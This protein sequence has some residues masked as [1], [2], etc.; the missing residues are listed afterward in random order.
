MR[1]LLLFS[2]FII[3]FSTCIDPF[4]PG[5]DS[6]GRK[7]VVDG[8]L[9]NLPDAYTV[10]L[11]YSEPY[12]NDS[13]TLP[14]TQATV[15][16]AD[17][18]GN[19]FDLQHVTQG[20]Y[21][22][23]KTV[24]QG[25]LGRTYTLHIQTPDGK[26]YQSQPEKMLAP[27]PIDTVFTRFV[28]TTD[29][30]EVS[31]YYFDAYVRTQDPKETENFYQWRWT[32]FRQLEFCQE[33]WDSQARIFRQF[34]CC[35]PCWAIQRCVGSNCIRIESD[36]Y[37]NGNRFESY[38]AQVPFD[39]KEAYFIAIDQLALSEQTY[40]F[41]Q[42]VNQQLNNTGGI[43]DVPPAAAVGNIFNP[44]DP[45]EQVLGIFNVAGATRK[46]VYLRRD[47]VNKTPITKKT[48]EPKV[49]Q[50]NCTQCNESLFRTNNKPEGW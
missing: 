27:P 41:W 17:D 44:A 48:P 13:L 34:Y 40:R 20:N 36:L 12:N 32:H 4:D 9:T 46:A 29:S 3:S 21:L 15:Y 7:L 19:R 38:V 10:R 11:T 8:L 24:F 39:S 28:E 43:F 5:I 18:L 26:K 42:T 16:I 50:F 30:R 2:I 45:E 14:I 6:A 37:F 49:P 22:S 33:G 23:D 25:T 31:T 35:T 47:Y 1:Q